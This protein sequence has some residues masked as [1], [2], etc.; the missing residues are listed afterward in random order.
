MYI[1]ILTRTNRRLLDHTLEQSQPNVVA[2]L[3][4]QV[5]S[6]DLREFVL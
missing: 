2:A 6:S 4:M 5:S 1:C 3:L